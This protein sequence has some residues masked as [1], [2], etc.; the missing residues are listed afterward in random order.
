MTRGERTAVLG[1][2]F[3]PSR[4][5]GPAS[6]P[7]SIASVTWHRLVLVVL[8]LVLILVILPA[9]LGVAGTQMLAL[10]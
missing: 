8:A 4:P 7:G 1:P 6:E 2:P 3:G 10:V 5:G 9:V